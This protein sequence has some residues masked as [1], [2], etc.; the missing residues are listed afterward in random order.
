MVFGAEFF[1][2]IAFVL[3]VIGLG[4]LGVHRQLAKALDGRIARVETELADA[5]RLRTEALAILA[6]FEKKRVEA[7]AEAESIVA[8]AKLEAETLAKET[9]A[10]MADFVAR[11]TKQAEAKI[12][13]AEAQATADV[14]AAA[15][16]AATKAAEIVL[17]GKIKGAPAADLVTQGIDDLKRLMH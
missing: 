11:R 8:L 3:F 17:K 6:S 12:A 15:A 4:Y 16:E 13:Q 14:H 5:A 2:A 10:R 1:I 9:A 7:Q